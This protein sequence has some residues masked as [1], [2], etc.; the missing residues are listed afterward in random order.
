MVH[1][2]MTA[3]DIV[4]QPTRLARQRENLIDLDLAIADAI[5]DWGDPRLADLDVVP[6][7]EDLR[8]QYRDTLQA[9]RRLDRRRPR[10]SATRGKAC[11]RSHQPVSVGGR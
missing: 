2:T 9:L 5:R 3:T 11:S 7:L 4:S 1:A 10:R 6:R 8:Q